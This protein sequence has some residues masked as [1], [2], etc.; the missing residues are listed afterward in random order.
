M[1][2]V[3]LHQIVPKK[4]VR[5][6]GGFRFLTREWFWGMGAVL[7]LSGGGMILHKD[8]TPHKGAATSEQTDVRFSVQ[9]EYIHPVYPLDEAGFAEG[10]AR[11]EA[12]ESRHFAGVRGG[13]VPHHTLPS[14]LL[15]D[16]FKNLAEQHPRTIILIGPNH[17]DFGAAKALTSRADW[18]TPSGLL[19]ADRAKVAVL[20]EAMGAGE[21]DAFLSREHSVAAIMPYIHRYLPETQVVPL[22]FKSGV[23]YEEAQRWGRFLADM[24]D[25][26]TVIVAAVDFSH[27]LT[28]Q[29]AQVKDAVTEQLLK[30][31]D[32]QVFFGLN[33]DYLDSPPSI[34][35]LLEA[36]KAR[37]TLHAEL[38]EHTNSGFLEN[39]ERSG[40][41][42]YFVFTFSE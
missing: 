38:L 20:M 30:T 40:V 33:N 25:E 27:Y 4:V 18:Q 9:S 21:D 28:A 15:A 24:S 19:R 11:A 5:R 17:T 14:F 8:A 36:M 41:T 22:V 10:A 7:V 31:Y 2:Q 29:E 1:F 34:A 6:N 39:D 3:K 37:G 42:S 23:T 32:S 12:G 16:F 13:I 35:V 26:E